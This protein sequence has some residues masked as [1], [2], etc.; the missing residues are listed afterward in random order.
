MSGSGKSTLMDALNGQRP[1]KGKCLLSMLTYTRTR[2][3][4]RIGL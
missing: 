1:A 3:C 2:I 4:P